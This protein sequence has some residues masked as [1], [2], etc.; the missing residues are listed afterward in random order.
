MKRTR[1]LFSVFASAALAA[2]VMPTTASG[3]DVDLGARLHG[4]DAYPVATGRSEYDS[5]SDGRDVEVTVISKRL[6][7]ERVIVRVSG[8]RVGTMVFSSAGRAHHE[9]ETDNGD[10]VPVTSVGD[11]VRVLT[12][13][14][15][16]V[17][18]GKYHRQADD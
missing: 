17:A 11:K 16:L 5:D 2:V 18:R 4:S 8:D 6:A 3:A 13:N 14:G 9:W 1:T 7:G 12:D 10:H 15:T